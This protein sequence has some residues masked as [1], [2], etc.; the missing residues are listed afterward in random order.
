MISTKVDSFEE[1]LDLLEKKVEQYDHPS[2]I[3]SD[4][5]SVPHLFAKKQ[6]IEIIGFWTAILS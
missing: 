6:D 2:F 3:E 1:L 5:I 4:P